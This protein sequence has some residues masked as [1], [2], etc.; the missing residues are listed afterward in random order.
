MPEAPTIRTALGGFPDYELIDS[1]RRCKLE[2]FGAVTVIRGEPKAWWEPTL[3]PEAWD[4]AQAIHDED[5]GWDLRPGCPREWKLR[6]EDLTFLARI[7]DTSKHLGIFP[8]QAPHWRAIQQAAAPGARLLNLF[9]YT[10]A[11]TLVA[12]AAGWTPTHVDA[13]KPATAW[14]R[15]NQAASRLADRPIRWIVEDA[16]KY[17]RREIKRG[18]RYDGILLD[19]PAFGRGPDGNV[20]KVERQLPELLDL[21]RAALS[22]RPRLLLL[23]T[24]NIEASALMLRNLVADLMKPYGGQIEVGELALPHS[25]APERLLPLSIYARWS[26][27]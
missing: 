27:R 2:R 25:S 17:V 20:W 19:P 22:E 12:A 26:A 16:V 11:A 8:E 21:C 15:E 7:S 3:P 1:G 18:S 5:A 4:R 14:A 9:G 10:G 23:T 24:Y 6:F 13:S